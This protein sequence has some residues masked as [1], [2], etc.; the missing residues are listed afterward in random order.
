MSEKR[1]ARK[2][3]K[4]AEKYDPIKIGSI[5]GKNHLNCFLLNFKM[6]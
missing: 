1:D 4:Y 3:L 2:W 5:D 6:Y